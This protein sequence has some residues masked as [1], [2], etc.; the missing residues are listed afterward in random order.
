MLE[1]P[2]G[3]GKTTQ[4]ARLASW[5]GSL[6]R[7]VVA[8]REPGGTALGEHL[9]TLLKERSDLGIGMTA[10]M[11]LFMASRAQLIAEVVR[12]R[13]AAGRSSWAIAIS[14]R[15]SS[16]RGLPVGSTSMTSGGWGGRRPAA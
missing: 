2:D 9:R 13:S 10:E 3:G 6:G 16:T 15:T 12:P 5:L 1:G 4:A 8:C 14:S 7:E 11:L